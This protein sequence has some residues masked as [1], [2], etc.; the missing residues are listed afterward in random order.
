MYDHTARHRHH[1][2]RRQPFSEPIKCGRSTAIS[3]NL[4]EGT[5]MAIAPLALP[6]AMAGRRPAATMRPIDQLD[7][8]NDRG[9]Q[10]DGVQKRAD[11]LGETGKM[12][13]QRRIGRIVPPPD[14]VIRMAANGSCASAAA[15]AASFCPM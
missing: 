2:M 4:R 9:W 15:R 1:T 7:S 12:R 13:G 14:V 8:V 5:P 3:P 10:L 11:I 6:C